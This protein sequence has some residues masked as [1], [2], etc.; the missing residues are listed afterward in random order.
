MGGY[1][2]YGNYYPRESDALNAEMAQCASIDLS[3]MA[4]EQRQYK[5]QQYDH[6]AELYCRIE[7]L[8]RQVGRLLQAVG[9]AAEEQGN[10]PEHPTKA[11]VCNAPENNMQ[12]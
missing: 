9:L 2:L 12:S 11:A 6:E 7:F 8:E 3:R 5:Q 1:D 4:R 10:V